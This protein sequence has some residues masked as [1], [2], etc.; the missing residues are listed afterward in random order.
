MLC[1]IA[2]KF[3]LSKLKGSDDLLK[4]L[5]RLLL[6]R[7][8][9]VM[10]QLCSIMVIGLL[11]SQLGFGSLVPNPSSGSAPDC[12]AHGT[13]IQNRQKWQ[14]LACVC[15]TLVTCCCEADPRAQEEPAGLLRYCVPGQGGF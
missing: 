7:D 4:G 6:Q 15:L 8:G 11:A 5:H 1:C 2:V 3:K 13:A 9:T 12:V 14:M 10:Q